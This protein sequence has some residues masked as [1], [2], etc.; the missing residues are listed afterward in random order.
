MVR[1]S[2]RVGNLALNTPEERS[3]KPFPFLPCLDGGIPAFSPRGTPEPVGLDVR[4]GNPRRN[5]NRSR[6]VLSAV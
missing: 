1:V 4:T 3:G 6:V 2:R 5:P